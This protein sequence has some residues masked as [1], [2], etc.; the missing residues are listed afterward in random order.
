MRGYTERIDED[1]PIVVLGVLLVLM[2]AVWL[3]G[4]YEH[5]KLREELIKAKCTIEMYEGQ[6]EISPI[7]LKELEEEKKRGGKMNNGKR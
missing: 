5:V 3:A 4:A 7:T 2:I 6:E 1:A